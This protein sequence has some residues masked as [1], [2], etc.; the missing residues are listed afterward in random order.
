MTG[1]S[2][3]DPG[4]RTAR[5]VLLAVAGC[6]VLGAVLG[7]VWAW[8]APR[9]PLE[10]VGDGAVPEEYQP[11]GFIA[12]DGV[13][14][15][16]AV[17][18]GVVVATLLLR[19]DGRP[20]VCLGA[21]VLGGSLGALLMWWVGSRIG[22]VDVDAVVATSPDGTV[23]DAPLRLRMPGVLL[24]WPTAVAAVV[25]ALATV[26]W[27]LDRRERRRHGGGEPAAVSG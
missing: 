20:L 14:A 24:L 8:L 26:D 12:A 27:W 5:T 13:F 6:L 18:A 19:W 1:V 4:R 3:T 10:V 15:V 17:L 23:F 22:A 25:T 11:G 7:V 16:L 21:G 9:V 2:E